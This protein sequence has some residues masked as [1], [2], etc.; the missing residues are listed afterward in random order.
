VSVLERP[1]TDEETQAKVPALALL[2][3]LGWR[4]L[5]PEACLSERGS[6]RAVLLERV[7]RER[8]SAHR[9]AYRGREYPLSDNG[10]AQVLKAL[11]DTG[12]NEGLTPANERIYKHLSLGVT[13][14]EFMPD[15]YRHSVTVPLIDFESRSATS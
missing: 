2:L 11:H 15:G 6:E 14:T 3:K 9:F 5:S 7:L 13:V 4:Y 12:L 10:I 8:L 1:R